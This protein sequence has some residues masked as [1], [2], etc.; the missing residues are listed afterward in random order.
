MNHCF[1]EGI[2][3][4]SVQSSSNPPIL[5]LNSGQT[6]STTAR[7]NPTSPRQ[8]P[9]PKARLWRPSGILEVGICH[10]INQESPDNISRENRKTW[11]GLYAAS[12]A[13]MAIL[14][15]MCMKSDDNDPWSFRVRVSKAQTRT[16]I[17]PG[18]T[19]VMPGPL[20]GPTPALEQPDK[21]D[22]S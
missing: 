7:W 2:L 18:V 21:P 4:I 16:W 11:W 10:T 3:G 12:Y 9:R 13:W 8:D 22:L 5:T 1:I 19:T 14:W 15:E 20:Q 6:G 17:K